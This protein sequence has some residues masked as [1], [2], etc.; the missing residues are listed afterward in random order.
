MDFLGTLKREFSFVR[1]NY[2]VLLTSW[3]IVDFA[4]ELP[5]AYF[6]LY[7]LG[8]GATETILGVVGLSQFLALASLQF[9][10]G[11]LADKYGRKWLISTMTFGVALSFILYAIAPSWPVVLIGVVLMS[12]FNS[13]YQPALTAMV[14]DSLPPER[15][16]MGFSITMLISSASTTPSPV[17]AALLRARFGLIDG[18]R[19][20][21]GIVVVLFLFAAFFRFFFLKETI[22][23]ASKPSLKEILQ[24]YPTALR[25]SVSVWKELPRSL[26]YLFLSFSVM[27]IGFSSTFL[28]TAVYATK[29]LLI[30]EVVWALVVAAI[31]VTTIILAI[32]VGKLVDKIKRKIPILASILMFGL[33]MWL[34]VYGDLER[35]IASL[36]LLGT[37]QVMLMASFQALQTDLT[38]KEQR[39][40]VSGFIN[41]VT[42][43]IMAAGSFV[44]GYLYE[45]VSP[46]APFLIATA[47][48]LPAFALTLLLVR[49][50]ERREE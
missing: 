18:M 26:V 42:F 16:G 8:L 29:V 49:E 32:P 34:F 4:S 44:G 48:V 39:G 45:H 11:Y 47:T 20:A 3:I 10:G 2:A 35:V 36:I 22:V 24:S 25:K 6:S 13:V 7:V 27:I 19:I 30:D 38:P 43:I 50:P 21:Y 40:K 1:G 5:A 37:G 14:S 46:Q 33:S 9:P 31:P 15:R 41:F 23:N 17:V 28:L 12:I